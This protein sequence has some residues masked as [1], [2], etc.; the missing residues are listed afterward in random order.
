MI[1]LVLVS[2][3]IFILGFYEAKGVP[4]DLSLKNDETRTPYRPIEKGVDAASY[5]RVVEGKEIDTAT[6]VG[7]GL[8]GTYLG[9]SVAYTV[10]LVALTVPPLAAGGLALLGLGTANANSDANKEQ[11]N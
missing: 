5:G 2:A 1:R 6:K 3:F 7:W 10:T 4:N 9:V 11:H 8:L